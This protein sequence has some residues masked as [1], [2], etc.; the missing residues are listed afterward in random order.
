MKKFISGI[1]LPLLLIYIALIAVIFLSQRSLMY[2]PQS[3]IPDEIAKNILPEGEIIRVITE[4]KLELK[5]Y[6]SPPQDTTKPIIL[7]FHGNA[8]QALYMAQ[9]FQPFIKEGYGVLFAEYRGY[10]GNEG[11]PTEQGLYQDADA[12]LE[13]ILNRF[14]KHKIIAY[15][16]SLGSAVA[17]DIVQRNPQ[18]FSG[19]ILEVPF[20]S[21]LSVA[22]KAY[23]F[24]PFKNFLLKDKYESDKKI[25]NIKIPK[26]F[27][28]AG[29]DSVVGKDSGQ[30]LYD[31]APSPKTIYINVDSRH[32]DILNHD[33]INCIL[34]FLSEH[35]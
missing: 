10:N 32:N 15:G 17:V 13:Y 29:Q 12:Y 1:F 14:S 24:I 22:S 27:L 7:A 23:P 8:S 33:V 25:S 26:L 28:V 6:V 16:Q 18:N 31:L 20:D 3:P 11:S 30:R 5:A 9:A 21:A 35:K 19:L 2:F 4:D 34:I